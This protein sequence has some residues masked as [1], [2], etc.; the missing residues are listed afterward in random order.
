[1][2]GDEP[3]SEAELA[4]EVRLVRQAIRA[5]VGRPSMRIADYGLENFVY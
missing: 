5:A 2:G 3:L 4:R 1:V